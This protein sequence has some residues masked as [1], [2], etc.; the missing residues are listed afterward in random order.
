MKES[1][2]GNFIGVRKILVLTTVLFFMATFFFLF[3]SFSQ[4]VFIPYENE[5]PI[6]LGE[7]LENNLSDS[8]DVLYE[9]TYDEVDIEYTTIYRNKD[10]L[11]TGAIQTVQEGVDGRQKV[12]AIKKYKDEEL[13]QED[14]L[15]NTMTRGAVDKIVDIGVG[16]GRYNN[17]ISKNDTLYVTSNLLTVWESPVEKTNKICTLQKDAEV[18]VI[19]ISEDGEWLYIYS[20]EGQGYIQSLSVTKIN[21]NNPNDYDDSLSK[22]AL[23]RKLNINMNLNEPSGL[24]LEQ[25]EKI[26]GDDPNDKNN[27]F[28]NNAKYFYYAEQQ[29]HINGVFI[30]AVG[31][32]ESA[33]GTST[34]ANNKKNLFGYGAFDSD[35]YNKA[36]SFNDYSEG[37]DLIARVFKKYYINP[38]GTVIYDGNVATGSFYSGTDLQSINRKY[39]SDKNWYNKVYK[40]MNY[41]YEK[42]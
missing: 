8:N 14:I 18:K 32:H 37:I 28:K 20:N 2:K 24:S 36:Y 5:N 39:A 19:D 4:A 15:Q 26:L 17:R 6:N 33:W 23:M 10:D 41:L 35:P 29:Y 7:I 22:S 34:I 21:P 1:K 42:L 31:V 16:S 11:P 30:A 3:S 25:F 38:K 9:L 40:W 12:V 13:F 27:V